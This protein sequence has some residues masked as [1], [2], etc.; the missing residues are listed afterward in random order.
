ME[1]CIKS[2]QIVHCVTKWEYELN[3]E[4]VSPP[5]YSFG[6]T[7]SPRNIKWLLRFLTAAAAWFCA[8]PHKQLTTINSLSLI[9]QSTQ[10]GFIIHEDVSL[11][12]LMHNSPLSSHRSQLR[13][14]PVTLRTKD[15]YPKSHTDTARINQMKSFDFARLLFDLEIS[16]LPSSSHRLNNGLMVAFINEVTCEVVEVVQGGST[17]LR[18]LDEWPYGTNLEKC[19]D[20]N[21][22]GLWESNGSYNNTSYS[23]DNSKGN[24]KH[25]KS[26]SG[27]TYND[28][29]RFI[30]ELE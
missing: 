16:F 10:E 2:T 9:P 23:S 28:N 14:I 1:F 26:H 13:S 21:I 5:Q 18:S 6:I 15:S 8:Y 30:S 25:L 24:Y 7:F 3:T 29:G 4:Q 19:N 22:G 17:W 20:V 11:W 27:R 12:T